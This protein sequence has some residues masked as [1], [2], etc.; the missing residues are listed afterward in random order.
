MKEEIVIDKRISGGMLGD[1][2]REI[3]G[4]ASV[5][6]GAA[7]SCPM[8]DSSLPPSLVSHNW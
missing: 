4:Y 2:N 3:S 5:I 1:G 8:E 7:L 6:N